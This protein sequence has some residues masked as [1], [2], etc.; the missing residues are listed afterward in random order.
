MRGAGGR[1][2]RGAPIGRKAAAV[3]VGGGG[4]RRRPTGVA[5]VRNRELGFRRGLLYTIYARED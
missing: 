5:G 4:V 1:G 3:V 2:G